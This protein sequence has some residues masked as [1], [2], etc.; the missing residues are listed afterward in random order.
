MKTMQRKMSRL[1]KSSSVYSKTISMVHLQERFR[2]SVEPAQINLVRDLDEKFFSNSYQLVQDLS[3]RFPFLAG[4]VKMYVDILFRLHTH[5][6]SEVDQGRAMHEK[7]R[8]A[9]EK[10]RMALRTTSTSEAM[11]EHLR[12]SLEDAWRNEDATKNREETMQLQLMSLVRGDQSN[13]PRAMTEQV[14]ISTKDLQ[15]HRLVLRERDRLAAELKDYQKRLHTNRVYS[16]TVEGMIEVS[17]EIISKLNARVKK[18]ES[19]NF[20]LEH[21]CNVEADKYEDRLLHLNKEL[22]TVVQQNQEL[23][24]ADKDFVELAA[25]NDAL[26]QRN[27]RLSREN[28]TLTKSFRL[29]EEEKNKLQTS[30]KVADAFNDAQRRDKA[31]LV[32]ARRAAERDAKKKADDSVLL[33]RRFHLLAKKNTELNDQVLVKQNELKVQEKKIMMATVK[34]DEAIRQ[35]EEIHRSREK[36]RVEIT[37]LNDIVAGV[38]HEIASIRHQM[39]DL[40]TDLLRAHKQLDEKDLQVQ[41]IAREKREQ[42]MELNDAYKKIDGIEETLALKTE[43]LEVL[44]VELQQKQLEFTNVKKQMEVIH[45]EKVM[46]IKS[47]D[48]CSRDR[49]TLQN[50]MTKLTHQINQMTSSLA[51]NEKEISSLKNQ[52][53]QLNRTV[54]QKQNEI[55]SKSRLLASTKS[56]LREMKIRLEQATHT[57][58]TD[59]KRFKNMACALDEVTKEKSLLGLQMVRRNDEVRLL[60]EKLDMMQ[61]AIDRGTMQYN[62]RVEDIRLLKLEVVNLRTSHE[63]MQREVGNKAAMRHDVIRL[64]RQLNQERLRVSAYSEELSRPCRI[65]RW[66]VMLGKDPRRFELISKIQQLLKRNIRLSVERENKAKELAALEHVHEEFKRQMTY[67]PDPSVRQKLCIQQRINRRQTRQL[68]VMKAELRI[69]EIDLK[70]REHLIEGFQEQLRLHHRENKENSTGR[71]DFSIRNGKASDDEF[72]EQVFDMSANC[73]S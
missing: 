68:K 27:D 60:K 36:L 10:L 63:C 16:E 20:R 43:R 55:H 19:E 29:M 3:E 52:I 39:Q 47:M 5:Y 13:M 69:N 54:K 71:G 50:T 12:E 28:H 26:K 34:L 17:K 72:T 30:L 53:E 40:L 33:E 23:L 8:T 15:L 45:S 6:V 21:R 70:A 1:Q 11:M 4:K 65:H 25:I 59:E 31:D 37:R 46:L 62:Q 18:A 7:V 41:K 32:M 42:S 44:Q 66:R 48:M 58:D 49:S 51:I 67:L 64:E 9:D 73:E 2:D 56:D 38:R 14:P 24:A 61:K 57:I 22:A 35:K